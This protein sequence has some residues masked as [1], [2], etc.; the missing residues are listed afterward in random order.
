MDLWWA[1][2]TEIVVVSAPESKDRLQNVKQ[3][4]AAKNAF[5]AILADGV[6]T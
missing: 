5:A 1:G 2:A 6:A 3:I 4:C